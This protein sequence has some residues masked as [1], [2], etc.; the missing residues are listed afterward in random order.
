MQN[1]T[2]E[3]T[4]STEE[5]RAFKSPLC[6]SVL[7]SVLCGKAFGLEFWPTANDVQR[8]WTPPLIFDSH[9]GLA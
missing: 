6:G 9:L 7:L 2:T 4:G 3:D 5:H 8:G 1:L